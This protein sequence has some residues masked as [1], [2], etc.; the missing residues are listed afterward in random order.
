MKNKEMNL[1]LNKKTIKI[2]NSQFNLEVIKLRY[3]V[4]LRINPV[5]I[6]WLYSPLSA[7]S[8]E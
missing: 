4:F 8:S 6:E 1:K 3:T 5:S 7:F 2:N